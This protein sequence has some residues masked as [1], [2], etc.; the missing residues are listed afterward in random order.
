MMFLGGVLF[1]IMFLFAIAIDEPGPLVLPAFILFAGIVW[2]LYCRLFAD[3]KHGARKEVS[4][5]M[6]RN[7]YLPPS[8]VNSAATLKPREPNTAEIIQ[9]PSITEYTTNL[10]QKRKQP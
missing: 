7:E 3:D 4:A 2:A 8:Q 9:P 6:Y 5:P 10:L 1:P